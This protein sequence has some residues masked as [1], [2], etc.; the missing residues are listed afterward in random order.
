MHVH[1]LILLQSSWSNITAFSFVTVGV[2]SRNARNQLQALSTGGAYA[3]PAFCFFPR[4]H[5][6]RFNSDIFTVYCF[7]TNLCIEK[8]S[9]N[10]TLC[11][12]YLRLLWLCYSFEE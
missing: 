5:F 12:I 3:A 1:Q 4:M 2:F 10:F 11:G 8:T 9:L 6:Y 7:T